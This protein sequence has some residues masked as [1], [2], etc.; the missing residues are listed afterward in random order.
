MNWFSNLKIGKKLTLGFGILEVLMIALGVFSIVQ[1]SKVNFSTVDLATSWMPSIKILGDM[2]FI[3]STE[4]RFELSHVMS[5]DKKL[6]AE[7]EAKIGTQMDLLTTT[8][9]QYE[10]VISSPE[11][12]KLYDAFHDLWNKKLEIEKRTLDL[13]RE[14]KKA[15][16]R[17]LALS[18]GREMFNAAA[19]KLQEDIDLN[20]KGGDDA[21]KQGATAYSSSRY[22]VVGILIG[23]VALGLVIATG[24]A[25]SISSSAIQML[26]MIQEVASNN[27]TVKDMDI[28][29]KDE[30]GQAGMALNQMKNGLHA[31]VQSIAETS[32]QIAS[33]SE[34]LS[35]TS[36][37]ITANSEETSA[38]A[39]VVSEATAKV[40]QNLQ[41]VATGAEEMGASI[42]EIAKNATEAARVAT[43]AVKVA[44]TTT[45]TVSKLGESSNE[46]GQVIKVITSIAQQ[47]NFTGAQCHH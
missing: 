28:R 3:I 33:A 23:A 32:I 27:L 9:K 14:S 25:R 30:I 8:E 17:D 4:R 40:S 15:E 39:K 24:L 46:I 36:Q 11:E 34:E 37:Q 35:S 22:W 1:L 13:S 12:R 2:R 29:S 6:E 42:K 41:T 26:A 31:V 47:T 5:A 19:D 16:A 45:A 43:S 10:L 20:N 38:Q 18:T 7:Y 44:E 21:A